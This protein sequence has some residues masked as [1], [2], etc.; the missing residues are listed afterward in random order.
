MRKSPENMKGHQYCC[1]CFSRSTKKHLICGCPNCEQTTN[2]KIVRKVLP[3]TIFKGR[4]CL[5]FAI[6]HKHQSMGK[7]I[8]RKR[9]PRLIC[10]CRET[11][12]VGE[13]GRAE[14]AKDRVCAP[15]PWDGRFVLTPRCREGNWRF[16]G[17]FQSLK[18]QDR[19]LT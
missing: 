1:V 8:A 7:T 9:V 6:D 2:T 16:K 15:R 10:C 4:G 14:N 5:L 13:G 17:T 12:L 3:S 11:P 19:E 18:T